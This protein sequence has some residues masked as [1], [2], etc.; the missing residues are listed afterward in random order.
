MSDPKRRQFNIR[1]TE[2]RYTQ[3]KAAA[4]AEGSPL[5]LWI[6]RACNAAAFIARDQ[7]GL[8]RDE[9]IVG[10][11]VLVEEAVTRLEALR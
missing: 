10:I 6:E 1:L 3:W 9:Q 4:D 8:S 7:E 2:E 11:R 5:T